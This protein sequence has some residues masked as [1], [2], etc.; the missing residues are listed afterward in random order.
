[1][2]EN[3]GTPPARRTIRLFP[4]YGRD[5][6]LWE[7]STSTWDVGYTTTPEF[8]GLSEGLTSA[9]AAWNSFWE[10]HLDPTNGWDTRENCERWSAEGERIRDL[11]VA[12][13][14]LFA[15]VLYEPGPLRD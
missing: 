8:Y 4:D 9:L 6:P 10:A 14:A 2:T 11:L 13:V 15:D 5:W 3:F 12:E 1:M 7:D